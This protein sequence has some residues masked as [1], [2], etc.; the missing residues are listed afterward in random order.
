MNDELAPKVPGVAIHTLT[1]EQSSHL[2]VADGRS[3][4][5]DCHS[6][7][8]KD[9]IRR[10]QLPMP[11]LILHTHVQPEHCRETATFPKARILVHK[12]L[13]ELAADQIGYEDATK[14]TWKNPQNWPV[15][16]GREK[17]GIGGAVTVLPPEEPLKVADTFT[18]GDRITW[19]S[20]EFEVIDLPGHSRH[21][22]GFVLHQPA[23]DPLC[24]FTGDLFC[25]GALVVNVYD[26]E[27]AYSATLL[28]ELPNVLRNLAS[29]PAQL[30][31][32][33]TGPVMHDGPDQARRLADKI[34]VYEEALTWTSGTY[35]PAPKPEGDSI[36]RYCRRAE[37]VCQLANG[38]GNC[39]MFIDD[40]GRGLMVDPGPCDFGSKTTEQDFIADLERFENDCGL[41]N[42]EVALLTHFHGDHFDMMPL[43]RERYPTCRVAAWDLVAR[44]VQA[45]HE[46]PY[47]CRMP[48]YDVGFDAIKVDH[49]LTEKT[50]YYWNDIEISSCHLPGH[51]YA[52]A[53]YFLTFGGQRIALTGDTIQSHGD[54]VSVE[55]IIANHSVPDEND[56]I[57]KAY[58]T[59][60]THEVDI[61]IGGHGSHFVGCNAMYE[62]SLRRIEHALP[63]LEALVPDGDIPRA[64]LRPWLVRQTT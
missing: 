47:A 39:I 9:W 46:Y 15:T 52:H 37:G 32:P 36:G 12:E 21:H 24:V 5:I 64:F 25:D 58:R 4:L 54:S 14:T 62:E 43:L 35:E 13:R 29:R 1:D 34:D 28:P 48:W 16:L 30:Y 44:V 18:V 57:L 10:Q 60:V 50:P 20:H 3:V 41:R 19:Q 45:P 7:R 31:L 22:V 59:M 26:L 33:A 51:C 55:Y 8:V 38:G 40:Q 2:I 49:I 23:G 53:A 61:N 56:G 11:E 27:S 6:P 42:V 17:Y 63:L